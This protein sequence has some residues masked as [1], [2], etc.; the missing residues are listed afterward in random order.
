LDWISKMSNGFDLFWTAMPARLAAC[1]W[2]VIRFG[3]I[4]Q[5]STIAL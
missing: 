3:S 5:I 4:P 1:N 2:G